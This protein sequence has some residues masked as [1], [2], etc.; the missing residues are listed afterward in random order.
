MLTNLTVTNQ[1]VTLNFHKPKRG[2]QG[3]DI[4]VTWIPKSIS[5]SSGTQILAGPT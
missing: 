3:K 1:S 2:I 5:E 4:P